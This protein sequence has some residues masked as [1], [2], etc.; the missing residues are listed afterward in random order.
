MS[1]YYLSGKIRSRSRG[2]WPLAVSP[3]RAAHTDDVG[4]HIAFGEED[5]CLSRAQQS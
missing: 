4:A 5:E 2:S 1:D 3:D